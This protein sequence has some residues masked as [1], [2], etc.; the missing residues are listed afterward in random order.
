VDKLEYIKRN[1]PLHQ[2][3]L[4]YGNPYSGK[5][6]YSI[7]DLL[8]FRLI[9][10][11]KKDIEVKTLKKV[12]IIELNL[13]LIESNDFDETDG[14]IG[15]LRK[16]CIINKDKTFFLILDCTMASDI[17]L[18]L[19]SISKVNLP[20]LYVFIEKTTIKEEAISTI[21]NLIPCYCDYLMSGEVI[22]QCYD[23]LIQSLKIDGNEE[24]HKIELKLLLARL[25]VHFENISL[26]SSDHNIT[27]R[28][29]IQF[30]KILK[31]FILE[32]TNNKSN[33]RISHLVRLSCKFSFGQFL[34]F[35][36]YK[37]FNSFIKNEFENSD[38]VYEDQAVENHA[39]A[40]MKES[41]M[42]VDSLIDLFYA[43]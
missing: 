26:Q 18:Y 40:G 24:F 35:E 32:N 31:H 23:D 19:K 22:N 27:Y 37:K 8:N 12:E 30:F 43:P 33:I 42:K 14:F 9:K 4:I 11:L 17:N 38:L 21:L 2:P 39:F 29:L 1:L 6:S 13:A 7:L 25:M 34:T 10:C 36:E 5:T 3:F 20:N 28:V 16:K 15:N 41:D